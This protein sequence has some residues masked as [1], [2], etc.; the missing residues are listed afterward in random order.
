MIRNTKITHMLFFKKLLF[1]G[2]LFF[3]FFTSS[4][5]CINGDCVNGF[6]EKKYPDSSRFLGNFEKGAKKSGTYYYPNGD[7]YKGGFEKNKRSGDAVYTHKNTEVFKGAF[8]DDKKAYGS[9][10]FLNGDVY[11]GTFENNKPDGYGTIVLKNGKK[12][13]GHWQDGKRKW[14]AN[15]AVSSDSLKI[16]SVGNTSVGA[17]YLINNKSTAPR[18]FAVVVGVA[19]YAG[20]ASDLTYSDDD[21]R[22]FYNHLKVAMPNEMS[23]G[24]SILLLNTQAT[25]AN[26]ISAFESVFSQSTENDFLIFYFS[27]HGSPGYF[28]PS[29]L[30]YPLL[31]HDI[32]KNYFKNAKAKYRLCIADACFSGTI[33]TQHQT[34]SVVNS[35]QNLRD[36]RLAVIMSS[37]PNQTSAETSAFNQGVF[38]H[39]LINGLKGAADLNNDHYITMGELFLYTKNETARNSNGAQVPVVY[40]KNLDLIPLTRLKN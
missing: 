31:S 11:T 25:R 32:V 38:S 5:Q 3:Y 7:V 14:G 4:A 29:D 16:D 15:I 10:Y 37:K 23:G 30:T 40:G 28:C 27:G 9:Y 36:A 13:E 8:V 20:T 12:W 2:L 26:I 35:T 22:I 17:K 21:A 33:G 19:D 6:G 34:T 24:K 39:Y 18:I 1:S